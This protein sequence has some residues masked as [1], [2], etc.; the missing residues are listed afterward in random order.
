MSLSP[1]VEGLFEYF[2]CQ[3]VQQQEEILNMVAALLDYDHDQ[4]PLFFHPL[5][6]PPG[7]SREANC[8]FRL[9]YS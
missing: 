1:R 7:K 6:L 8:L 9:Q 2:G 5:K 4:Q 3:S